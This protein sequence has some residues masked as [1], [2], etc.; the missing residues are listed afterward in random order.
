MLVRARANGLGLRHMDVTFI[1]AG[2]IAAALLVPCL[3]SFYTTHILEIAGDSEGMLALMAAPF[4]GGWAAAVLFLGFFIY[5]RLKRP[6]MLVTACPK[7]G[8]DL[9]G[10]LKSGCPECG[11]NRVEKK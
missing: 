1:V 9:R 11:W 4:V 3:T 8:Y 5:R 7:C 10:D 2:A 6:I